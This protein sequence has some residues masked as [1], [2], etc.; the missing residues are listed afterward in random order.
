MFLCDVCREQ[1]NQS[2]NDN[3]NDFSN[4]N[5]TWLPCGDIYDLEDDASEYIAFKEGDTFFQRYDCLKTYPFSEEDTQSVVEIASFMCETHINLDGRYDRNRGLRDNTFINQSNFNLINPVY[6][7]QNNFFNYH[8]LDENAFRTTKFPTRFTWSLNKVNG[9]DIDE[10]TR[11]NTAAFH[12]CEGDK[13]EITSL[14]RFNGQIYAFQENGISRIKYNENVAINAQN[15][16]PIE[17]GNSAS[18]N[19]VEY[20]SEFVGSQNKWSTVSTPNGIFFV[21]VNTPGIY[22]L[23]GG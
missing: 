2:Y 22:R 6:S 8:I 16:L 23:G 1:P 3:T 11:T 19:G 15:G 5:R 12:D 7:Q 13:G 10:W 4:Q 14:R 20:L 18:V 17:L 21:D 9:Q